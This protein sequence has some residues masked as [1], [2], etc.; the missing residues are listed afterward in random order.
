MTSFFFRAPRVIDFL[1]SAVSCLE[2][3]LKLVTL[4]LAMS[5][6]IFPHVAWA[7]DQDVIDYREHIMKSM[8]EQVAAIGEILEQKVNPENLTTHVQILAVTAATAKSAFEPK[9]LGGKAKP[10]V[11]LHWADFAKRLDALTAATAELAKTAKDG[12]VAAAAPKAQS[13]LTCK[14]CHDTYRQPDK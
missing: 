2:S 1:V 3:R 5:V 11:W 4:Y 7:D 14:G 10:E 12:G 13:A 8:G 9:V 6:V